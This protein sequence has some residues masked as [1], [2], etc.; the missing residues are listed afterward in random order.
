VN[1]ENEQEIVEIFTPI[2]VAK[3]GNSGRGKSCGVPVK[4]SS[5]PAV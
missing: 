3:F 4:K 5:L 2:V 1:N